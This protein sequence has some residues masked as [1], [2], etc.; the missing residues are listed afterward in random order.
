MKIIVFGATGTL[1]RKVVQEALSE[2]HEV[3]AF[4]RSG[5]FEHA[6]SPSLNVVKG[7]VFDAYS[8]AQA[9]KGHE[10][11]IC[12]L[13]AGR[14]GTVRTMGTKHITEGM[15]I[16]GVKRFVCLSSL[17]VGDSRG[18]LNFLWKNIMFGL[19]LRPAY[20]DHHTQEA[21]VKQSN[22]DWTIVRPSAFTDG[23]KTGKYHRGFSPYKRDGLELKISRADAAQFMV[24]QL[25]S[26]KY[27]S[28]TPAISY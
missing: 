22:L 20:E 4:T 16:H 6:S 11:V 17:G 18:N 12:A 19:L 1:G 7:D 21:L 3:T 8:V 9:V 13:G 23:P 14:K 5:T 27:L 15:K 25:Q 10:G 28:Q 26:D 2:G 24:A